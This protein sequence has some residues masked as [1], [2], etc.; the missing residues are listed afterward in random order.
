VDFGSLK[1]L[2]A[3]ATGKDR[4]YVAA[5]A[6]S[7]QLAEGAQQRAAAAAARKG[8]GDDDDNDDDDGKA[9]GAATTTAKPAKPFDPSAHAKLISQAMAR[10]GP[11]VRAEEL[12]VGENPFGG[13]VPLEAPSKYRCDCNLLALSQDVWRGCVG[14]GG[15][16]LWPPTQTE[17]G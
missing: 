7:N 11:A 8:D 13:H 16:V 10:P 12:T 3:A 15:C 14:V 6:A 2:S 1:P 9:P 5:P 17:Y 4:G